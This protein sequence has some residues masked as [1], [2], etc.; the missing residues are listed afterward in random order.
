MVT[1]ANFI[2]EYMVTH[3][4]AT[5]ADLFTTCSTLVSRSSSSEEGCT[6]TNS[7][8]KTL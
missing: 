1:H 7:Y 6:D 2:S 5:M 8:R 4:K 3:A